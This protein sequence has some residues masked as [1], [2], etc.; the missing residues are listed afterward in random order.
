VAIVVV[1]VVMH[2]VVDFLLGEAM[3]SSLYNGHP[4]WADNVD[5]FS[6]QW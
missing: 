2:S 6:L 3:M 4:G 5:V 1:A